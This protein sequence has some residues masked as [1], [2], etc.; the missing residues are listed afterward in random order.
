MSGWTA[1]KTCPSWRGANNI[2]LTTPAPSS[3]PRRT[4]ARCQP[5]WPPSKTRIT[6]FSWA[7][8][9]RLST[10]SV[11]GKTRGQANRNRR[12]HRTERQR[13]AH[14]IADLRPR[15]RLLVLLRCWCA[16]WKPLKEHED[17]SILSTDVAGG[18]VGAMVGPLRP[19]KLNASGRSRR[20]HTTATCV[21]AAPAPP[22]TP[23]TTA[24]SADNSH[25]AAGAWH[26]T[27]M[28]QSPHTRA[29]ACAG[30]PQ[31]G[32]PAPAARPR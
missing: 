6:G 2:K 31:T 27:R 20:R 11:P 5:V 3:T 16:G 29:P 28:R 30:N 24:A 32:T 26:P 7:S 17:G 1:C 15:A 23:Q 14:Q 25:T 13:R 19:G 8:A 12:H 18:F 10:W 4:P 9:E 21:S 22:S